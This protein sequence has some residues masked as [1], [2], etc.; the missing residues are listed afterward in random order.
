MAKG[1]KCISCWHFDRRR[2]YCPTIDRDVD[3]R[4]GCKEHETMSEH[5]AKYDNGYG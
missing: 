1:G 5:N 4:C 3:A 2:G